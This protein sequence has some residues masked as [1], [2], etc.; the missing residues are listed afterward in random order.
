LGDLER[1]DEHLQEW[2]DVLLGLNPDS[3]NWQIWHHFCLGLVYVKQG[4]MD[5]AKSMLD[6]IESIQAQMETLDVQTLAKFRHKWL[7][8]EILSAEALWDEAIGV[9]TSIEYPPIPTLRVDPI[10]IYNM[11]FLNDFLA[12]AYYRSGRLDDA[13]AEYER[14]INFDPQGEDRRLIHPKYYYLLAKLYEEKGEAAKAV[15]S[16]ERFLELW[17]DADPGLPE[18]EDA[19][20]KLASLKN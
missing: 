1:S 18:V 5:E 4:K 14:K 15:A 16:Y 12:R 3:K 6:E 10:M 2:A 20:T 9:Y 7:Y 17:K 19:K 11:P 8:A 13:I